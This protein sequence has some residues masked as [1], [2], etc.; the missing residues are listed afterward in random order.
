MKPK[1]WR[2]EVGI[3]IGLL[4]GAIVWWGAYDPGAGLLQNPQLII[5]PAAIACIVVILRNK[6]RKV[7]P[8]DP[9]TMARNRRG[10]I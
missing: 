4:V 10:R 3:A 8:Y 2:M 6:R 9:E 5:V 7:G 1:P